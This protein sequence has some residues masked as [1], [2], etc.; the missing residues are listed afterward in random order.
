MRVTVPVGTERR[1]PAIRD[2]RHRGGVQSRNGSVPV[3]VP[4][5]RQALSVSGPNE[6]DVACT[7]RHTLRL[8]GGLQ[9][10][11]KHALSGLEP[12]PPSNPWHVQ[13]DATADESFVQR[14]HGERRGSVRTHRTGGL[15]AV[16]ERAPVADVAEGI[17]VTVAGVMVVL[18]HVVHRESQRALAVVG[19]HGHVMVGRLRIVGRGSGIEWAAQAEGPPVTH[20]RRAGNDRGFAGV[21]KR[22]TLV[23]LT[24]SSPR[25]QRVEQLGELLPTHLRRWHPAPVHRARSLPRRSGRSASSITGQP[26]PQPALRPGR[27]V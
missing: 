1:H 16:V 11:A 23:L 18:T 15:E 4:E 21:V 20:E 27:P 22:P 10:V 17:D 6:Q 12:R 8:L 2:E 26:N 3:A 13:E 7:D 14:L 5:L 9:V 25:R 19:Q 24:P